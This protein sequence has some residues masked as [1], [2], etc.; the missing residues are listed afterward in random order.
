MS[1]L[2]IG[3]EQG[4]AGQVELKISGG[5]L[6]GDAAR[7]KDALLAALHDADR[8]VVDLAR[9]EEIDLTA[10]QL[11][12]AAHQS[13]ESAGKVFQVQ[14]AGNNIYHEVVSHAG[15]HRHVGCARDNSSSCIWVG[16]E[17]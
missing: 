13:A 4:K 6:I 16:G 7:L 1:E 15:L 3:R 2:E 14:A 17:I 11:L 8:I 9:M 12:C 5:A 10:L